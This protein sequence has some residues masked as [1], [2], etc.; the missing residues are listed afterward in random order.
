[1]F[2]RNIPTIHI[3]HEAARSNKD[4]E[5]EF[6]NTEKSKDLYVL[7]IFLRFV[8]DQ[9]RIRLILVSSILAYPALDMTWV[10]ENSQ[11]STAARVFHRICDEADYIK[12]HTDENTIPLQILAASIREA[13][14]PISVSHQETT[15]IPFID[16]SAR[17]P[18]VSDWR[19]SLYGDRYPKNSKEKGSLTKYKGNQKEETSKRT[20]MKSRKNAS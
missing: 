7:K 5:I 9:Y 14:K 18:G 17:E 6:V 15:H 3:V 10:F 12:T 1:M 11:Y 19:E 20:V 4:Y 2:V 8:D 13:V 16:E